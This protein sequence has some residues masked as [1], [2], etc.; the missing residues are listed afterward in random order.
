MSG[1]TA[2]AAAAR[3]DAGRSPNPRLI[4]V[5]CCFSLFMAQLDATAVNVAMPSIGG[6]LGGGISGLQWV[7]DG[8][9]LALACLGMSGGSLGDRYGRRRTYRI[10]LVVFSLSSLGCG[11]APDLAGLVTLRIVQ[12]VGAAML[13]PVT[14]SIITITF[15]DPAA[16]ARAIGVWAGVAGLAAGVGPMV[17]GAL[18][19]GLGWRAIFWIN[20]PVGALAYALAG[21]HIPESR[22]TDP[23]SFDLTGQV[24]LTATMAALTYALIEAPAKG[25]GSG[26]TLGL[27]GGAGIG[28][29]CFVVAETR[30]RK[31]LIEP[32]YFQDR[33]FAGAGAIACLAYLAVMGFLFMNSLYLQRV[34]GLSPLTAGL[35]MLP[36][37]LTLAA[38][39]LLA[40]RLVARY[41]PRP[42]LIASTCSLIAAMAVLIRSTPTTAPVLLL[43]AYLLLGAGWGLLNPPLT[44]V[45]ITA[46]PRDQ[47]GVASAS[48]GVS[49]QLG[50][51]LGVAIMGSL[52]TTRTST[53]IRA[54]RAEASAFTEATH[55]GYAVGIGAALV[56]LV[57]AIATMSRN[58]ADRRE[59]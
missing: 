20:L 16:R 3:P 30:I 50:A 59:V 8:Y 54:G 28:G 40:G 51:V 18:A 46:M 1:E 23:G 10:G 36:A 6:S 4:L 5:A 42:V 56:G 15:H 26:P 49:R 48:V 31:P 11:L 53:L 7:V 14:L 33:G 52:I 55:L 12:G 44:N 9:V 21:R 38:A 34:R 43:A 47:A 45:A 37:S 27:L 29:L 35:A 13:M 32:R 22:S 19:S 24:L 58:S 2:T 39:S 57:I 41:G 17:G 25:W